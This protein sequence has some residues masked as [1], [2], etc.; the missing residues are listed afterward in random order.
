MTK[1]LNSGAIINGVIVE[2]DP[3][4]SHKKN[5]N[6][7]L[8]PIV[9]DSHLF[10]L[11]HGYQRKKKHSYGTVSEQLVSGFGLRPFKEFYAIMMGFPVKF[12]GDK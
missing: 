8:T 4:V 10:T 6:G 9:F 7:Y 2:A 11:R 1:N 3:I 5:G 12:I